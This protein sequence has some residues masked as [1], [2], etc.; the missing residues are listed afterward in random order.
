VLAGDAWVAATALAY[1]LPLVTNNPS[2]Y[3]G[4][5]GLTVISEKNP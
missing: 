5:A 4:V 3:T 1:G 2:D